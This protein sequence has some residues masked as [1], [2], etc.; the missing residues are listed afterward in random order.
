MGG[1]YGSKHLN[2]IY[3]V[4]FG[5]LL[6]NRYPLC[7]RFSFLRTINI[8]RIRNVNEPLYGSLRCKYY[9][10]FNVF[11]KVHVRRYNFVIKEDLNREK[12]LLL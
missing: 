12:K 7:S 8:S 6:L 9:T 1:W 4:A 11:Y 2:D 5:I 10:N 3:C